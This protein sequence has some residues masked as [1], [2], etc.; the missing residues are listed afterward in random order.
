MEKRN[1]SNRNAILLG[2]GGQTNPNAH[3]LNSKSKV[4]QIFTRPFSRIVDTSALFPSNGCARLV[5]NDSW[6]GCIQTIQIVPY[7]VDVH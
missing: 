6:Y 5:V 4:G 7:G 1:V 2:S 3:A